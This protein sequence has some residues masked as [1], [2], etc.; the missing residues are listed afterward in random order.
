MFYGHVFCNECFKSHVMTRFKADNPRAHSNSMWM[1]WGPGS[2]AQ[3]MNNFTGPWTKQLPIIT[4]VRALIGHCGWFWVNPKTPLI[5][6][7]HANIHSVGGL[8]GWR[9]LHT[10]KNIWHHNCFLSI[11]QVYPRCISQ[12]V[13]WRFHKQCN[14]PKKRYKYINP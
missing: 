13:I 2:C 9:A 4:I 6:I 14:T 7:H 5:K 3:N 10:F 1:Q 8:A 12:D 11:M